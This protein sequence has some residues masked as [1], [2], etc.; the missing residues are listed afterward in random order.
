MSSKISKFQG[1][2][3]KDLSKWN[4]QYLLVNNVIKRNIGLKISMIQ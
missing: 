3:F 4:K 1:I 2:L